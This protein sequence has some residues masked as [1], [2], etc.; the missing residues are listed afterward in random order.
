MQ[1]SLLQREKKYDFLLLLITDDTKCLSSSAVVPIMGK[2]E[3]AL[4]LEQNLETV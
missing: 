4:A 1:S 3:I 2:G